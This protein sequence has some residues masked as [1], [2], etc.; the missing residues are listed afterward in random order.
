ML[1]HLN[2]TCLRRAVLLLRSTPCVQSV[3]RLVCLVCQ[4]EYKWNIIRRT[5]CMSGELHMFVEYFL[6]RSVTFVDPVVCHFVIIFLMCHVCLDGSMSC[7]CGAC[8]VRVVC[9]V[10]Q[11]N[12][13]HMWAF[14]IPFYCMRRS[15]CMPCTSCLSCMPGEL[16]P[17]VGLLSCSSCVTV[18][19]YLMC[20]VF[21]V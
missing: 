17:C 15:C 1:C 2:Y 20:R 8:S 6:F 14:C 19:V 9:D 16:L 21:Q 18:A 10:C 12:Y 4:V 3:V 5:D 11:V 13:T 7:V